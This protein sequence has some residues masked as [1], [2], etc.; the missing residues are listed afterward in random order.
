MVKLNNDW[1]E[2]LAEE[3]KKEYYLRLREFLKQEYRTYTIYPHMD[4]IFNALRLTPYEKVRAVIVGQ[5][6]YIN[7]G[8]AHGLSFSVQCAKIPPSLANIFKEIQADI[9]AEIPTNG[10]LQ[11]WA[12][13]GVLLLNNVLT[14][15]AGQSRSHAK[16][17]WE[18]FTD[19]V[20]G[21]LDRR[22]TP[23]AFLLWGKDAQTKGRVLT[24][25]Q[26]LILQAAHPSPLA[27]GRFFGCRHFSKANEFLRGCGLG[28]VEW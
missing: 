9:G 17:G 28:E 15:R 14:V 4:N 7:A 26:H 18:Q 12:E 21:L 10:N 22:E 27:G 8:E 3:F 23:I 16:K 11:R 24:N 20:L 5:D 13:Q 2:L 1:D 6:P 25:R 19:A